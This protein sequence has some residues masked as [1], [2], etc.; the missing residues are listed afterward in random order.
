[1]TKKSI[2]NTLVNTMTYAVSAIVVIVFLAIDINIDNWIDKEFDAALTNKASYLKTLVKVTDASQSQVEFDFADEFMPEFSLP[3]DGEYFQLWRGDQEFERSDSLLKFAEA[4]LIKPEQALNSSAFYDVTLPDG[5]SGRAIVSTFLPQIPL[6]EDRLA[7]HDLAPMQLTLAISKEELSNILIIID[8]SMALGLLA[9]IVLLRL[10]VMKI[11]DAG[12]RPLNEL[13]Q[14]LKS[15]NNKDDLG[16][17]TV[18]A[19]EFIEIE[20][21]KNELN[22][23]TKLNQQHLINEKRITADIAHELKTPISELI[24][25]TEIHMRYPDDERISITYRQDVLS[26]SLKMKNVVSNLLLLQQAAAGAIA[27][28][29]VELDLTDTLE[30]IIKEQTTQHPQAQS[31][32]Q[33]SR[34]LG[35]STVYLDEFSIHCLLSNLLDNALFYSPKDSSVLVRLKSLPQGDVC[36]EIENQLT[37]NLSDKDLEKLTMPLFQLEISRTHPDRHGLGLSIVEKISRAN[38][39]GFSIKK[40]SEYSLMATLLLP[41]G[42]HT[43]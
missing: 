41:S 10:M 12:L 38:N 8:T 4:N 2:K 3:A 26:I 42:E 14:Q 24:N 5:R 37:T 16:K 36:I 22:R 19:D 31:R 29:R 35:Q 11:I 34:E 30:Q 43:H 9:M 23:F 7:H 27:V 1:M 25:L 40:T 21:I 20:P 17:F 15:A 28:E 13:N 39:I 33:V 32:I 18:A 6:E